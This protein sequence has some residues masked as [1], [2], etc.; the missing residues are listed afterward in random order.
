[1]AFRHYTRPSAKQM[2]EK[3]GKCRRCCI[4]EIHLEGPTLPPA[5][6]RFVGRGEAAKRKRLRGPEPPP[7]RESRPP[8]GDGL[9]SLR[10]MDFAR[11]SWCGVARRWVASTIRTQGYAGGRF[12]QKG[13]GD[14]T[15]FEKC[16]LASYPGSRHH[17]GPSRPACA[18]PR[19]GDGEHVVPTA[20]L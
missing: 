7:T 4:I 1:M 16:G 14:T 8:F 5:L 19:Q 3:N 13:E 18:R 9:S 11:G 17:S 12:T 15:L 2:K 6:G 10:E 20:L